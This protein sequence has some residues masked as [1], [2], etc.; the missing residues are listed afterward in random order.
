MIENGV[1][2]WYS[3]S[4]HLSLAQC[5]VGPVS[6]TLFQHYTNTGPTSRVCRGGKATACY[7]KFELSVFQ[8][9]RNEMFLPSSLISIQYCEK[10]SRLRG[11]VLD[12]RPPSCEV[13]ILYLESSVIRLSYNSPS[14][15]YLSWPSTICMCTEWYA[16]SFI[17]SLTIEKCSTYVFGADQVRVVSLP[18]YVYICSVWPMTIDESLRC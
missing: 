2:P 5:Y 14:S 7:E 10:P 12:Q 1:N 9:Q 18:N 3:L 17:P 13:L 6:T 8:F 15:E 4:K 16:A 11:I